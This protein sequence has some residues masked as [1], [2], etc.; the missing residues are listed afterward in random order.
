MADLQVSVRTSRTRSS[1]FA[2]F[3]ALVSGLVR[4]TTNSWSQQP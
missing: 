1:M 2:S 4:A 3:L